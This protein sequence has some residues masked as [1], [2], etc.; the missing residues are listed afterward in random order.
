MPLSATERTR[1]QFI[2]EALYGV[3]GFR[4]LVQIDSYGKPSYVGVSH[5]IPYPRESDERFARRNQVAW[6]IRHLAS[7]C[8]RFAGY[9]AKRPPLRDIGTN[10]LLKVVMDD[11]NWRGDDLDV[12]W[13]AFAIE[14][15][16][17]GSMLLLVDM[18]PTL[19]ADQQTQV[20]QRA[21]P[22]LV[23]I[24][25]EQV[26]EY[27][28]DV[29]GRFDRV[30]ISD[31][32]VIDGEQAFIEREWTKTGWTIY[33]EGKIFQGGEHF[34]GVCPVLIFT[35]AGDYP[36]F[37]DYSQIADISK[38]IFNAWSELDELLRGQTFSILLYKVPQDRF[39]LDLTNVT[40]TLGV[41]NM[42]QTFEQGAEFIGPDAANAATYM[43]VIAL[44]EQK[45]NDVAL[46]VEATNQAESGIALTLR[47]QA[48][49]S[50][51]VGFARR[52][53]DLER[54]MWEL[55]GRWLGIENRVQ[56]SWSK[57]YAISDVG[58]EVDILSAMQAAAMPDAVLRE[59]Q[60]AVVSAQFGAAENA[61]I[62][63]LIAA[64]DEPK[65]EP[66]P[67]TTPEDVT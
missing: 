16:A 42:L 1:F 13:H 34:L 46:I 33:R 12:F 17:R 48:L 28:L 53:E 43:Q 64:I 35:E 41:S 10:P 26:T 9:L 60:K 50:S 59:Q 37:G 38:R 52:M 15:K 19:P 29:Q 56:V 8:G 23:P 30:K 5:L 27:L 54:R 65:Q 7:A 3:G 47:F 4:P 25:P 20:E 32:M 58:K 40:A 6:Y 67:P 21:V 11:C 36:C 57:D 24:Y 18:P 2:A 22:Y 44:M 55:V 51:L 45:I 49:N 31:V 14:A 39:G 62:D 61:V 66:K 63:Q